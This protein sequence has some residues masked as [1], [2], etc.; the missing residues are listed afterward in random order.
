MSETIWF[1]PAP[2]GAFYLEDKTTGAQTSLKTD[3]RH[4]AQAVAQAPERRGRPAGNQ[5]AITTI[6]VA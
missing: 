2:W 3:Q 4:E 5:L 6:T 1:S